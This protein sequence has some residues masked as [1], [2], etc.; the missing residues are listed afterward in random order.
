MPS[1]VEYELKPIQGADFNLNIIVKVDGAPIDLTGATVYMQI[2]V[3][4]N[5][6]LL[7]DLD[8]AGYISIGDPLAGEIAVSVPA[9]ATDGWA[10][11][12]AYYDLRILLAGGDTI[13][14]LYGRVRMISG[15]TTD[16]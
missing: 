3:K 1:T 14:P 8:D 16:E 15:V 12:L 6:E 11:S 10:W 9:A 2:R 4:P 7:A 5:G 13:K